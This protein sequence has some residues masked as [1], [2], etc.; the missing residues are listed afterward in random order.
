MN[1]LRLLFSIALMTAVSVVS[2]QVLVKGTV[3]SSENQLL[4]FGM[5]EFDGKIVT[6]SDAEGKFSIPNVVAGDHV[7]R[8]VILGYENLDT[9][10]HVAGTEGELNLG[11]LTMKSKPF[12]VQEV[13]ISAP[14]YPYSDKYMGSS[15][16]VGKAELNR[17]Q[18]M[19]SEEV[20][21]K[22]AGVNVSG[23]MGISNRLNVGIR[24]SYP[25]RAGNILLLEDGTP[26][27]PAPYLAPEAYYNPPS[28]RLDGIEII[29]GADVLTLGS[30]TV[31]GAVNYITKKPPV[32]PTFG[33][34]VTSGTNA[35]NSQ[36]LTYG[37][38]WNNVGAEMQ[39]LNKSF[40]GFQDN[41][42]FSIFNATAK[43]YAETGA[44]SSLYMKVNYHQEKAQAS[45]SSMTPFTF[46]TDPYQN[47]FDADDLSTRRYAADV[48][49]NVQIG[50][51]VVLSSKVYATQFN[52]DWW[53][54]EN[55]LVKAS[56]VRTYVGD[57]IYF[58]RYAYLEGQTFG[59][60]DWVRVGKIANGR[61]STKA[62]NRLFKVA[63]A[64][65][66]MKMEWT[67][68]KLQGKL[69]VG[70]KAHFESF[71]NQ[72]IKNDS[73]RFSRSGSIVVDELFCLSSYSGYVKNTF[74]LG[75]L[76]FAPVVRYE[77]VEMTKA[78]LLV[79]A[80]SPD[81]TGDDDFGVT[82]NTFSSLLPGA[83][84]SFTMRKGLGEVCFYTGA[85]KGYTPPTSGV[86]FMRVED[87]EV[88]SLTEGETPN[89][90]PETSI[91]AEAGIRFALW[92]NAV[93]G[94][95]A[96]F[97]NNI[98]N[99]YSAGR[100]EAFQSLGSV[101]ISGIEAV[102]VFNADALWKNKN[103]RLSLTVNGTFMTSAI[104]DGKLIDSDVLKAK[105]TDATKQELI[106]KINAE[107][108]GYDIYF[109]GSGGDSLVTR[110]LVIGDFSSIK[111]LGLNFGAD[112]IA[113]NSVPYLP[114][115]LMNVS[116]EYGWKGFNAGVNFNYVG[117]QYT[118]YLNMKNETA[119]G[120]MGQLAAFSNIDVCLGYSFSKANNKYLKGMNL[121]VTGKNITDE[122]YVASR[123][124]RVSSGIMP[125]GF[126]QINAGIRWTL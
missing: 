68:G 4:P 50:K 116:L 16:A 80:A 66:T 5:V 115:V 20:L 91:N 123:L 35:Y 93:A 113:N 26:I 110:D 65:E 96:I 22:T 85:Y 77:V 17:T 102:V 84:L 107:R 104:T 11:K 8:V 45:Y 33:L 18:P 100:N 60:D 67:A 103:H 90:L 1:N 124:H 81:N 23:D 59:N 39:V 82:K 83:N 112:G 62:R 41:S 125:G 101:T 55:T 106:D 69:E 114:P 3:V 94:Q 117:A 12:Q 21:K 9:T 34:N 38:T 54:Q 44:R 119:E 57:E 7:L 121:F 40:G 75:G 6:Q 74:T 95:T 61:E 48:V 53:R 109:T 42:S 2:A 30:N 79:N 88:S 10:I 108:G 49:Y 29:K 13:V 122:I 126:R 105:H 25:R 70:G 111:K 46:R 89:M 36:F 97:R 72:E 19:G 47:P 120:A 28:D 56:S 37:G 73:S 58:D 63:G 76:A 52:R 99:F 32:K 86:G 87:E 64:Q 14:Q 24:G 98:T 118:D 43:V 27:A 51:S 71:N 78:D 15:S 31:Y 92:K